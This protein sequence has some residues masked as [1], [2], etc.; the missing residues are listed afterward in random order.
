MPLL[1]ALAVTLCTAMVL[2]T[3]SV[4]GGFLEMLVGS[5]RTLIGDVSIEWPNIGFR[6]Y[7][8]LVA[9]LEEDDS[10][11]AGAAPVIDTFG[12]LTFSDDKTLTI[13]VRGVEPETFARV[14]TFADTIWWR[15]I[16]K[17]MPGD[18]HA[19]DW[20][21]DNHDFFEQF[22]Q[23]GLT[24]TEVDPDT[25][26]QRP[27]VVLGIELS[28]RSAR[29]PGGWY[30]A[31]GGVEKLPSGQTQ[32]STDFFPQTSITLNVLPLDSKG[33]N[34][35]FEAREF[36][37]ANEFHT[38][39]FEVDN[40]VALVRLDA[41]QDMLKMDA[42][43]RVIDD[44]SPIN[45]LTIDPDTN[46]PILNAEP[47]TRIEPARVTTVLVRAAD[48]VD[49]DTLKVYCE[50]VYA[51]FAADHEGDVPSIARIDIDTWEDKNRTLIAAVKKETALVLFIFSF[52]SLTAVFLVLSIFWSMVS[53]KTRDVGV[54]R[55]IGASRMGVASVW[56][57]YGAGIG[58]VGAV[59]GG[60]LA[61]VIVTNINPIHDWLGTALGLTI[62]DPRIYYFTSIPNRIDPLH[63]TIVLLGGVLASVLGALIPSWRAAAMDPVRALRFE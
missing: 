10:M 19:E 20:R 42:A 14:T 5:G 26:Q 36:P 62:W 39:F 40:T 57:G 58:I 35:D 18:K 12:V 15:P 31:L 49:A 56:L 4:M 61:Y 46:E 16:D 13:K 59:L 51:K 30:R 32:V 60:L 2:I 44:R 25:G 22:L 27:A 63:A 29:Q 1:A 21:L 45:A 48:G 7:D 52:I 53:E 55:S 33:H 54:L 28:G 9:R 41:L 8:D 34:I 37:V 47:E 38:G 23:D 11:V 50:A 6:H 17:P 43:R 3:W 24:L